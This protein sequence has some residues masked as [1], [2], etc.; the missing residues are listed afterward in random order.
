MGEI[1]FFKPRLMLVE[2]L[3]DT[4][5]QV[6]RLKFYPSS[7]MQVYRQ[8]RK[9]LLKRAYSAYKNS[10]YVKFYK[11]GLTS[12]ENRRIK[13]EAIE[14]D[15]YVC[16]QEMDL[17]KEFELYRRGSRKFKEEIEKKWLKN[18]A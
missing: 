2:W 5:N 1:G 17:D 10:E 3:K 13:K 9:A 12:A 15:T 16:L 7:E 4:N 8:M 14:I 18:V 6:K 11:R